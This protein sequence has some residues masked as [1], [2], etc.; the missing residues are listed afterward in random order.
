M[1]KRQCH[2]FA[3]GYDLTTAAACAQTFDRFDK[4]VGLKWLY[5][6]HLNDSKRELGS[7]VDRHEP[8]GEGK[9]G[10][11][12]FKWLMNDPRTRKLPKYLETPGGPELW[13]KEIQLLRGFAEV[14]HREQ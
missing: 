1:Y 8:L 9:I 14:H 13:E 3:A 7:R 5:A 12:C 6:L 11:E 2:I 4:I 10:I